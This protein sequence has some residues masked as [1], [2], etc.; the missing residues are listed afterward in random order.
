MKMVVQMFDCLLV[1]EGLMEIHIPAP[2]LIKFAQLHLPKKGFVAV[3][4]PPH[5]WARGV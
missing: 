2:I 1:C 5:P 3:L 4:T